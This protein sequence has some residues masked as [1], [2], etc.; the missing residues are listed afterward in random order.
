M[1]SI[2]AVQ[3]LQQLLSRSLIA[4]LYALA[5]LLSTAVLV[6]NAAVYGETPPLSSTYA[7]WEQHWR[8]HL[9]TNVLG[10]A[11]LSWAAAQLMA[12]QVS[13]LAFINKCRRGCCKR[14]QPCGVCMS[15]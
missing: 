9:A 14:K 8:L 2:G 3:S 15:V 13:T 4:P 12:H 5:A 6:N 7:Q 11:C 10:P 1:V